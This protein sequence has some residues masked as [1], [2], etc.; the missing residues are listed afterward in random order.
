MSLTVVDASP[1]P[2]SLEILPMSGTALQLSWPTNATGFALESA[3]SLPATV[4]TAVTNSV[5]TNG[6][7]FRVQLPAT[8]AQRYFQL[9]K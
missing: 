7:M 4:W 1:P 2:P 5:A 6:E 8:G 9:R 3:T